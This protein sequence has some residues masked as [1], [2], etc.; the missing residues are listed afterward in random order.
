[1]YSH[2]ERFLLSYNMK[3]ARLTANL[4]LQIENFHIPFKTVLPYLYLA[5]SCEVFPSFHFS[6][7]VLKYSSLF[8]L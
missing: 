8:G 2:T 7:Y 1:M 4:G 5:D 6:W 3:E